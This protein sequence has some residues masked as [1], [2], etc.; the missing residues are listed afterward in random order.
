MIAV[1]GVGGGGDPQRERVITMSR[2]RRLASTVVVAAL[3]VTGLAA[4]NQAP[5]VAVYFGDKKAVTESEVQRVWDDASAK[6]T[7][8]SAMP[9]TR[10]DIVSVE[11]F[12][13]ALRRV[14]QQQSLTPA[15][16][17]TTSL[18]PQLKMETDATFVKL[19][20]EFQGWL[21]ALERSAT[22]P[23]AAAAP[24]AEA[25]LRD[26]Y[27]RI[28]A[29]GY[30]ETFEKFATMSDQLAQQGLGSA[31]KLRNDLRT[32]I[33][34]MHIK[35][36]PRYTAPALPLAAYPNTQVTIVDVPFGTGAVAPV[37]DLG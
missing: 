26:I 4:C 30:Q 7:D 15:A 22:A 35:I 5:D 18:G 3:A 16:V 1:A 17:P 6:L 28:K 37:I 23:S 32:Q 20:A 10:Q 21:N 13:Q 33:D 34:A 2:A 12:V 25:D 27:T 9:I 8:N 31:I 24:I 14:G 19:V 36:N 29:A 11:I